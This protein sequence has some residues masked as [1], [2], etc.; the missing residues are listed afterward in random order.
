MIKK[1]ITSKTIGLRCLKADKDRK[2]FATILVKIVVISVHN[3]LT[4]TLR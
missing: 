3:V 1:M 2:Q 4:M